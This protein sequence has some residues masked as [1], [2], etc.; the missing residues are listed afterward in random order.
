[1]QLLTPAGACFPAALEIILGSNG[2]TIE[3]LLDG[4]TS[5]DVLELFLQDYPQ[6]SQ[7]QQP[8]LHTTLSS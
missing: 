4:S 2:L 5:I 8:W 7:L 1:M 3:E 6:A